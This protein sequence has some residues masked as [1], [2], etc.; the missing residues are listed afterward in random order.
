MQ[1]SGG[2]NSWYL[3]PKIIIIYIVLFFLMSFS[4][5]ISHIQVLMRQYAFQVFKYVISFSSYFTYRV[6]KEFYMAYSQHNF[7]SFLPINFGGVLYENFSSFSQQ[8]FEE[9]LHKVLLIFFPEGFWRKYKYMIHEIK[10]TRIKLIK[11]ECCKAHNR[12]WSIR[13]K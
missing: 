9:F 7:S 10:N 6:L 8:G 5:K 11:G 4:L 13:W 12:W 1:G 2:V 3:N